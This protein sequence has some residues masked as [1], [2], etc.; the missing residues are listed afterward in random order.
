M[1]PNLQKALLPAALGLLIGGAVV[2]LW[3]NQVIQSSFRTEGTVFSQYAATH[4]APKNPAP[5]DNYLC[6][7]AYNTRWAGCNMK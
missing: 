7:P 5:T 4:P 1:N 2:G 3:V 6:D